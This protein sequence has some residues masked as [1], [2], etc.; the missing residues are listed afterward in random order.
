LLFRSFAGLTVQEFDDIYNKEITKR[1]DKHE[2]NRLSK[3]KD[4]ESDLLVLVDLSK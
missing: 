2:N 1:Y 4:R 3:R